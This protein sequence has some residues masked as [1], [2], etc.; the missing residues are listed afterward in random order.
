MIL[1]M[2]LYVLWESKK[3][4]RLNNIMLRDEASEANTKQE[5]II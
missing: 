4:R 5:K 3:K 1:V 2:K